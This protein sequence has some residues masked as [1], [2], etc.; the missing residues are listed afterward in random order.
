MPG[1]STHREEKMSLMGPTAPVSCSR[2]LKSTRHGRPG[3][4]AVLLIKYLYNFTFVQS[5]FIMYSNSGSGKK[6]DQPGWR[7]RGESA[8]P[9]KFDKTFIISCISEQ[10]KKKKQPLVEPRINCIYLHRLRGS[11]LWPV[12]ITGFN[13]DG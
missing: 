6:Y 7:R 4:K 10:G 2:W 11:P 5:I 12:R 3:S 9:I 8:G 13:T 1:R